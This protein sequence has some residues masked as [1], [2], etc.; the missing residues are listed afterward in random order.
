MPLAPMQ[1]GVAALQPVSVALP[2]STHTS[3]MAGVVPLHTP[4]AQLVPTLTGGLLHTPA[5][6][7]S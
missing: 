2:S 4:P 1:C 6:H 3:Q 5:V 7:T